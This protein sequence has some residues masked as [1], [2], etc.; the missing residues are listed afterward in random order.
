LERSL[1][2]FQNRILDSFRF[3][4]SL[5]EVSQSDHLNE[6]DSSVSKGESS[7]VDIGCGVEEL[8]EKV[9]ESESLIDSIRQEI[10]ELKRSIDLTVCPFE[11]WYSLGENS[12]LT[13]SMSIDHFPLLRMWPPAGVIS[14]LTQL[15][16]GN[17]CDRGVVRTIQSS[18]FESYSPNRIA[19]FSS[20]D[21]YCSNNNSNEWIGYD[22]KRMKIVPRSN[23]VNSC[24]L[25]SWVIEG[26]NNLEEKEWIELDRQA[27]NSS[28]N[29]SLFD[30][31]V[32]IS[33]SQ[34]KAF[35]YIRLR[36]T[37]PDYNNSHWLYISGFELFGVLLRLE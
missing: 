27:N 33:V 9:S 28:L 35:Q 32:P 34:E 24:H 17:V 20:G 14:F 21:S 26:T 36:M 18:I 15:Y 3:S 11:K 22:L 19:N 23:G 8:K 4:S 10:S 30:V 12:S 7:K 1:S 31:S 29:G 2:D 16:G 13:D 5:F 25:K 6:K 37:G